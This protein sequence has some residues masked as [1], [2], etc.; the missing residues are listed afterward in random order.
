[1]R[2]L[3]ICDRYRNPGPNLNQRSGGLATL[4]LLGAA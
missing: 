2:H 1:M 3:M 4:F